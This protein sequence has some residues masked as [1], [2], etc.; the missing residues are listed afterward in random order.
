MT[1]ICNTI[2]R[3]RDHFSQLTR[4]DKTNTYCLSASATADS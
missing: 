3:D 2:I 4:V 1:N